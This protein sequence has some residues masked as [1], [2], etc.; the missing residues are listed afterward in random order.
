MSFNVVFLNFD[1]QATTLDRKFDERKHQTESS[2]MA[3]KMV[4]V[5]SQ[6]ELFTSR[7]SVFEDVIDD[8]AAGYKRIG[9]EHG[10]GRQRV[11]AEEM[12]QEQREIDKTVGDNLKRLWRYWRECGVPKS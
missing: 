11:E 7:Q 5:N 2:S 12:V 3:E 10:E 4:Y 1:T 6:E 9:I 8:I